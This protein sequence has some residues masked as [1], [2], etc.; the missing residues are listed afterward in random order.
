MDAQERIQQLAEKFPAN[1]RLFMRKELK[2]LP[3]VLNESEEVLNL[4]QGRYEDKQGAVVVT[5]QRVLFTEEGIFRSRLEDF[6]YDRISSVQTEKGMVFGKLVIFASNNK[7]VIDQMVPK[8]KAT[9]I[10]DFVRARLASKE[11]RQGAP[12]IQAGSEAADPLDRLKK[13]A[14]LRDAGVVSPDEFEEKKAN[15]LKEM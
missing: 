7:V 1:I 3:S 2:K 13:L 12:G 11:S 14:E 15:I 10:G 4:A 5:D 6:P 9:E 8:E